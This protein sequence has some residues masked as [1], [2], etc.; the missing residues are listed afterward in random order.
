MKRAEGL[1]NADLESGAWVMHGAGFQPS[2]VLV[3]GVLGLQPRLLWARPL[4]LWGGWRPGLPDDRRRKA[5][6]TR[7]N[8]GPPY[9]RGLRRPSD[10]KQPSFYLVFWLSAG[11]F[12]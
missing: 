10:P 4:A 5:M 1:S 7:R 12:L 3:V 2:G 9:G 6:A 11:Y 8:V